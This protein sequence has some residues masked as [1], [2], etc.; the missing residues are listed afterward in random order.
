MYGRVYCNGAVNGRPA[1]DDRI[2]QERGS[3]REL[4]RLQSGQCEGSSGAGE[5]YV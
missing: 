1:W 4:N 5:V 3:F 2:W